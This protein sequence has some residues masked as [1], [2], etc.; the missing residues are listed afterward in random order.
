MLGGATP[1]AELGQRCVR[2]SCCSGWSKP[3]RS[4]RHSVWHRF[5]ASSEP[6]ACRS[7]SHR[8]CR[9]ASAR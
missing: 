6:P 2:S 4:T 3:N 8:P 5:L 7:R 1:H 9:S